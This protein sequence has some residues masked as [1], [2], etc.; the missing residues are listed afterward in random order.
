MKYRMYGVIPPMLTPFKKDGNL[1][2]EGIRTLVRFLNGKVNGVFICGSYGSGPLMSVEEKKKVIDIVMEEKKELQIV[3][4]TGCITT[5][6]TIELT[7]YAKDAGVNAA[8]AVAPFYYHY[9]ED[10]VVTYYKDV[11][12]AVGRDFPFY[13]YNNPK[14]SGYSVSIN[15][16]QKLQKIGVAGCKAAS[17]DLM[18]FADLMRAFQNTDF[19]LALGTEALWLPASMYGAK[20]FIP[21]LGN[22]FP[23]L[24]MEMFETS[25][26]G[27]YEK[28]LEIQM[29][30]NKIR[31]IM[32]L[33]G[34]TQLAI[35]AFLEL[36]GIMRAYPRKPFNASTL[37]QKEDIRKKLK[38]IGVL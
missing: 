26:N 17:F 6:D 18:E 22:A 7:N 21:G 31:D 20:A 10:D 29:E 11:I 32:Y 27:E 23:E 12:D 34:S 9:G 33:A 3:A 4:Q 8:S 28:C 30:I 36:R 24:C 2:E 38:E 19:D 5:K 25:Q 14:F 1:D 16:M 35:Y 15:T 13:I 37:E